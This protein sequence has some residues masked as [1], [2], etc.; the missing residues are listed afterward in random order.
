M[1]ARQTAAETQNMFHSRLAAGDL[2]GAAAMSGRGISTHLFN[3]LQTN[4]SQ[5]LFIKLL[6][7][8][9]P[10]QGPGSGSKNKCLAS[11]ITS[12][13]IYGPGLS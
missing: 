9:F 3:K 5:D 1:A 4:Q 13:L 6:S 11:S 8:F 10:A 7:I 2:G 12:L